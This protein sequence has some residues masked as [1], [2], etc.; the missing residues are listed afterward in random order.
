MSETRRPADNSDN[1]CHSYH[2][3]LLEL[4]EGNERR[5]IFQSRSV[6]VDAAVHVLHLTGC[7]TMNDEYQMEPTFE[8]ILTR[9]ARVEEDLKTTSTVLYN[10]WSV[11]QALQYYRTYDPKKDA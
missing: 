7:R 9:Y 5:N 4:V 2:A 6:D 8:V 11:E 1:P 10:S 3:P